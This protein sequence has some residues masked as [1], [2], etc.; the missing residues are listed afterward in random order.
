[1]RI[2]N[3]GNQP[4]TLVGVNAGDAA[5]GVTLGGGPELVGGSPPTPSE[6]PGESPGAPGESPGESP[7]PTAPATPTGQPTPAEP[8]GQETFTIEI[9]PG[10]YVLL[11]PGQDRFLQLVGLRQ[12]LVPGGSVPVTFMFR[13][14]GTTNVTVQVPMGLP[15]T[16]LPRPEP[17]VPEEGE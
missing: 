16:P 2:F 8:P 15:A 12:P 3:N 11:V 13:N 1:V 9:A 10:S 7:A 14:G 17:V 4:V 6:T 5:A